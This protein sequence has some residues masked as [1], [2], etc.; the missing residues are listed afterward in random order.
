MWRRWI[1]R[2]QP[3][4]LL[5][6][7]LFIVALL[8]SQWTTLLT[9]EWRLNPLWLTLS[10]LFMLASWALEVYIWYLLIALLGSH[11][12][13]GAALR[14][15]FLAALVRYIPGNVWQPLSLTLYCQ[16]RQV[17]PETT[18]ASIAL[19]QVIILLAVAP[20]AAVYF[21]I[22]GNWGIFTNLVGSAAPWVIGGG[23][24]PVLFFLTKPGWL[25][26]ICNWLLSKVGRPTI[27]ARLTS[28][29]LL[30]LLSLAVVDWLLWGATFATLTLALGHFTELPLWLF[31]LHLVASY[32]IA[33]AI[34]FLSVI[35]P[36][37]LGVREGTFYLLLAPIVGG[38]FI[39]VAALAMRLWN[40][41]GEVLMALI[42]FVIERR[43]TFPLP[44]APAEATVE[45]S[46]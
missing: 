7:V 5:F 32:P 11:L 33:H 35:T 29:S 46:H 21:Q 34:G 15:W 6:A 37:G 20:I 18:L 30:L 41:V 19:Y 27:A 2:L 13:Y 42:S 38:G 10:A 45:R 12:P 26:A 1:D 25:L 14:I 28:A 22:T 23:L 43:H 39:T 44:S 24:L 16:Q 4:I 31:S 36:S 9:Y 8:R 17:R 3:F 40:V